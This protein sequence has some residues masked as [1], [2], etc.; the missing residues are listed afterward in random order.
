MSFTLSWDC[1]L[2]EGITHLARHT[3]ATIALNNKV[4]INSVQAMMG[5][6]NSRMTQRYAKIM[7]STIKENMNQLK[8]QIA[9]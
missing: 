7:N 9:L 2:L 6:T 3:F 8:K 4:D 1:L 5:H